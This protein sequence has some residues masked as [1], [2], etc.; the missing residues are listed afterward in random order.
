MKSIGNIYLT[1]R[2]GKGERRIPIGVIKRN[3]TL[4]TRFHYLEEGLKDAKKFG[5]SIYEG[6]PDISTTYSKNV[7]EIF[8]QRIMRSERNDIKDFYDFWLI[9]KNHLND[10]YYMLAHTQGILPTDNYEF[11]A[12]FNSSK[13][14]KFITE[15]SGLSKYKINSESLKKGDTLTYKKESDNLY[16][17]YAVKVYKNELLLGY[18]K[19]IHN[20]IFHRSNR[21]FKISVQHIEK[22]GI[23]KRVFLRVE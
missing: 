16:D 10:V 11:L 6:F 22:N 7:I 3:K 12:E 14:L 8:G 18:I 23:L 19:I 20:R 15:I 13:D 1:W 2:K 17:K 21:C 5:F 9:D 4:G